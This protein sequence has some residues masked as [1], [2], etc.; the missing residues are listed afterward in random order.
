MKNHSLTQ[1]LQ[2][3]GTRKFCQVFQTRSKT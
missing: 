1:Y 2:E 3:R